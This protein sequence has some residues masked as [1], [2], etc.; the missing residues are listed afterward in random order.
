[1]PVG[2]HVDRAELLVPVEMRGEGLERSEAH[3]VVFGFWIAQLDATK[4]CLR[5]SGLDLHHG[6]DG[7]GCVLVGGTGERED[8][9][10]VELVGLADRL[11]TRLV[12]EIVVAVGHTEAVE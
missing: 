12:P 6:G 11:E 2:G 3:R 7:G 9:V 10:H 8:F 5:Q 4:A 1:M